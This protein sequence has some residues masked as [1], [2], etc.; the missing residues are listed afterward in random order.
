MPPITQPAAGSDTLPRE[1][2]DMIFERAEE[3]SAI[4]RV[5]PNEPLPTNGTAIPTLTGE[6]T[7]AWVAEGGRKPV[8]TASTGV[9]LLDPKKL[10]VIV[11]F[12][13]EFLRTDRTNLPDRLRDK[14]AGAFAAAFDRATVHGDGGSSPF[15]NHIAETTN[16]IELGTNAA[17][18]GGIH[19]DIIDG[20]AAVVADE[21]VIEAFAAT[22]LVEPTLLGARDANGAPILTG[23][24]TNVN[25]VASLIG[26][27]LTYGKGVGTPASGTPT[28][29]DGIRIV[30]GEWGQSA[31]GA[32][33]DIDY[34]VTDQATLVDSDGTTL[35][36]LWQEN[37]V[38]IR[39]EAFYG[40]V[41]NDVEA[42][43]K[44]R[45]NT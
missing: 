25:S 1:V 40:W 7:A 41:L 23:G 26:R 6:P 31:W 2:S 14:I 34:A 3:G 32:F 8:S 33:G 44:Y 20:L 35:L 15:T 39:A 18:A 16:D 13:D 27:P 19:Q 30:G 9:K 11:A 22:P 28:S 45:D 24:S 21:F 37:L 38:A 10:S 42:F 5:S 4:Q 36:H 12:S 43:V 29:T 17:G